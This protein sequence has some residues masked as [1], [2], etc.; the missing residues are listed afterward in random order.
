M[1]KSNNMNYE[2]DSPTKDVKEGYSG[3]SAENS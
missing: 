1:F 3:D 2:D